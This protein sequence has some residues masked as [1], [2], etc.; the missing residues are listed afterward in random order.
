[1]PFGRPY[2]E[3]NDRARLVALTDR[4][5]RAGGRCDFMTSLAGCSIS[6]KRQENGQWIEAVQLT[7]KTIL[8]A[9]NSARFNA[10]LAIFTNAKRSPIPYA[11]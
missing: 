2:D 9:L 7:G 11:K 8:D 6:I 3:P 1:M 5:R 4:V 10:A